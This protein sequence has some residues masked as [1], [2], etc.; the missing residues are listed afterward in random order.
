MG[1][2]ILNK[3]ERIWTDLNVFVLV[4]SMKS[5]EQSR[6]LTLDTGIITLRFKH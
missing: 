3:D 6:K 2:L 4:L 5:M 1:I